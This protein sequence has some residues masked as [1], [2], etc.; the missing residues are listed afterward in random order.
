M[1]YTPDKSRYIFSQYEATLADTASISSGWLDMQAADKNQ[2]EINSSAS[3]LTLRTFS[4]NGPDGTEGMVM[5]ENLTLSPFFLFNTVARQRYMKFDIVN[6]TGSGVTDTSLAIKSSFGSS[7]KASVFPVNVN[8]TEFSQA[9]LVQSIGRGEQPDGNFV[10]IPAD[11]LAISETTPLGIG[12]TFTSDWIDTD[13]W[14]SLEIFIKTDEISATDGITI[15]Y[16]RDA[17]VVSP[18]VDAEE[19]FTLVQL[20]IDNDFLI[21]R[22]PSTLDGFRISYTNGPVA[23]SLFD[24]EVTM[25]V[26]EVQNSLKF[27]GSTKQNNVD[28]PFKVGSGQESG[29]SSDIKYGANPDISS[30]SAPED[31]WAGG[32][33]YTGMPDHS[34]SAETIDVYSDDANDTSAGTGARTARLFGLDENWMEQEEDV[35]M[36]GVTPVTTIGLWHRMNKIKVITGGTVGHNI[37]S[38]TAEHTTTSANV[39]AVMPPTANSSI[40]GGYTVPVGKRLFLLKA[41]THIARANGGLGSA[42]YSIRTREEGGVFQSL[43]WATITTA[44]A[45]VIDI[46]TAEGPYP[47]KTDIKFRI[48]EVSSNGTIASC[49]FEYMLIDNG[50]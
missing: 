35:I 26:N 12:G 47:E 45:D 40:I 6:E 32:G 3:G 27:S 39:F 24:L 38:I 14:K 17:N 43:R 37:G 25:M 9:V 4:S 15:Q 44:F 50:F 2:V 10:T 34:A 21:L 28:F 5:T 23:Q 36:N 7:D 30:G 16:T 19:F 49:E 46:K 22:L 41:S 1:S 42:L 8:P 48:E 11:G 20:D 33:D 29:H 13:G 31:I 18:V